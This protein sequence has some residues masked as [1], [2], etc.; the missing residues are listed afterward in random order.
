MASLFTYSQMGSRL[1]AIDGY[2]YQ[3][4]KSYTRK[5]DCK[6]VSYWCCE[7]RRDQ[8]CK[9]TV[10]TDADGTVIK[11][12]SAL[13]AHDV[14]SGRTEALTVRYDLLVGAARRQEA[15]PAAILNEFVTPQVVMSLPGEVAM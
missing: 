3:H 10:M 12:V 7:R 9:V 13:H 15:A 8:N 11:G 6:R 14:R 4:N 5:C 2:L 1:L